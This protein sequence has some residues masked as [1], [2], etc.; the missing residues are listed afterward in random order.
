MRVGAVL[1]ALLALSACG[2]GLFRQYEYEEEMYLALDGSATLYVNASTAALNALRG[3]TFDVSPNARIDRAQVEAFFSTPVARVR[4]VK[5][6]RRS[7]RRFVHVR[8]DVDDINRL[9]EAAP[10]AWSTYQFG[11]DGDVFAYRQTVGASAGKPVDTNWTGDELVAFRLHLP[12]KVVFHNAGPDNLRRG[13]IVAWEQRLS[14]RVRNQP[15]LLETRIETES[16]LY[17]TLWLFGATFLAVVLLFI[18]VVWLIVRRGRRP[19]LPVPG[20]LPP[21]T[22]LDQRQ[23]PH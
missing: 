21:T 3:A 22:S 15:L 7:N 10:L 17:R 6:S 16:I 18:A 1:V 11:R 5:T 14:D 20:S 8:L 19:Q 2:G 12:S 23:P 9:G 13:N 4:S